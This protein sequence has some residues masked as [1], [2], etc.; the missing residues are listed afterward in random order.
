MPGRARGRLLGRRRH[1]WE[2]P[3]AAGRWRSPAPED[4]GPPGLGALRHVA[5]SAA[6]AGAEHGR[7]PAGALDGS[8]IG[9]KPV[10]DGGYRFQAALLGLP[11][12]SNDYQRHYCGGSLIGAYYVLTAAHCVDFIG[13]APAASSRSASCVVVGRTVLQQHG[14]EA[15]WRGASRPPAGTRTTAERRRRHRAGQPVTG[16]TP[17]KLAHHRH[18]RPRAP[19]PPGHH[20]RMGQH[21]PAGPRGRGGLTNFPDRMRVTQVPIVADDE[22]A[23]AYGPAAS[24]PPA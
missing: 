13:T 1:G 14:P 10:A 15:R 24:W 11:F 18:G 8:I 5:G 17:I 2:P 23:A 7:G 21:D 19:G 4:R 16:I 12:G 22:C 3:D 20:H 9:G 6:P